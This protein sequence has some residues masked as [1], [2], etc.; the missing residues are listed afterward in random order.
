MHRESDP[1]AVPLNIAVGRLHV[2]QV[3]APSFYVQELVVK[4]LRRK[5]VWKILQP[6]ALEPDERENP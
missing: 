3:L 6:K 5:G 1:A 2:A 4:C